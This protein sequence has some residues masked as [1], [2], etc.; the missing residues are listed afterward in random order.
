MPEPAFPNIGIFVKF[1]FM[2][3]PILYVFILAFGLVA[4]TAAAPTDSLTYGAFGKIFIYTHT[5]QPS[6][7]VL[8]IS[9]DGGWNKGVVSMG[10]HLIDHNAMVAGINIQHYF[11][12]LNARKEACC[13]PASDFENL[14]M[15]LQK[16]Y[17]FKA[18]MKPIL[19]GYSSGATLVY[20]LI[21]QA[22]FN[23]FKGG[24]SLGFCPDIEIAKPMCSG[25]GLKYHVLKE[26]HSYYLEAK[27]DLSCP[28]MVL[29]GTIDQVCD[30]N[31]TA[32]YL[33]PIR[34]AE[35]IT[36]PKV[37]HGFSV[38]RNWVPQFLASFDKIVASGDQVEEIAP[39][40]QAE[41]ISP[42]MDITLPLVTTPAPAN[43]NA[44]MVFMISGDGGW[45][46]FDQD[47]A[48]EMSRKGYPTLGLDAQKYFWTKRTPEECVHDFSVAIEE[49]LGK[50]H[51]KSFILLG[52]SFGADVVPFL[53]A[54]FSP[55]LSQ[56]LAGIVMMSPDRTG[57][58]EIHVMD[59]LS[60]G[61]SKDKYDVVDAVKKLPK[62]TTVAMFG[63]QEPP[64]DIK[65]FRD[66]GVA[67]EVLPGSHHYNKDA[68]AVV[69]AINR[70]FAKT[71]KEAHP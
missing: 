40:H 41:Y 19:V 15:Y 6:A 21:A 71:E 14:S 70:H 42:A 53:P 64:E 12:Q 45:T 49:Y 4:K 8:F 29:H 3:K 20:G 52:Y 57:D 39:T 62:M 11:K 69:N 25:S 1:F 58:F 5:M 2:R 36:L 47:I 54:Q 56:V 31:S 33:K 55:Y 65:A 32:E 9:G 37:G 34:K 18:Y 22:P 10:Y 50:W 13:Y 46:D 24:I 26:G 43:D 68:A 51:K 7:L 66:T 44:P 48:N 27:E 30:Y 63:D 61:S 67:I 38:E 17:H 35:L 28:L 59:M 60:L 23:T 16:K